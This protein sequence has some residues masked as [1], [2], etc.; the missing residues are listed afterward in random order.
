MSDG[1][2]TPP[3]PPQRPLVPGDVVDGFR[4]TRLVAEGAMGEV[5]LA[6]DEE[7]GRRVALKFIK[8]GSLDHKGLERFR[9]EA[10]V[11]ARFNHPHIVTVYAAGVYGG[12]PWLALEYLDGET[13]RE[14]LDRG[15]LDGA[16]G[17][18]HRVAPSPTPS[19]KRTATR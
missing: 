3:N 17:A 11:T 8:A 1:A 18:A 2:A 19:P 12:R 6:V 4:V 16:R 9:V 7:L 15:S 14:R 5:Y 13:L 10:R